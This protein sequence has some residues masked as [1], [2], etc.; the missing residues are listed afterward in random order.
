LNNSIRFDARGVARPLGGCLQ[1]FR[2]AL[3]AEGLSLRIATTIRILEK[4]IGLPWA[5]GSTRCRHHPKVE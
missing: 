2:T 1:L 5:F 3:Y 4:L